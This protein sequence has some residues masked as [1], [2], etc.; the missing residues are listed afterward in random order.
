MHA[1]NNNISNNMDSTKPDG[2]FEAGGTSADTGGI[3]AKVQMGG[4]RIETR[5]ISLTSNIKACNEG[6][7]PLMERF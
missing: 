4:L 1:T 2:T 6:M 5:G 7:S 3:N